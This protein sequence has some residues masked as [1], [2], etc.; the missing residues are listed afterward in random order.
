MASKQDPSEKGV[1]GR[2]LPSDREDH[3]ETPKHTNRLHV[4]KVGNSLIAASK[5]NVPGGVRPVGRMGS[6]TSASGRQTALMPTMW[7]GY[8]FTADLV[9]FLT[10][11]SEELS[12]PRSAKIRA[13]SSLFAG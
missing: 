1:S 6:S 3:I 10:A 4:P 7:H 5:K 8:E 2:G 9:R 12:Y 11:S 13:L